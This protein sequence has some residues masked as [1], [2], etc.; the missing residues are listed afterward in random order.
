MSERLTEHVPI[1]FTDSTLAVLRS[2]AR[3]EGMSASAWVRRVVE[4]EVAHRD[5][6]CPTCGATQHASEP[7]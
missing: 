5:G 2:L 1:R 4:R 3:A 7:S 6:R